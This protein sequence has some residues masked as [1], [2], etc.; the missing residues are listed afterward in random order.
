MSIN[1]DAFNRI[2]I[3]VTSANLLQFSIRE[4]STFRFFQTFAIDTTINNKLALKYKS[5]DSS[6]WINGLKLSTKSELFDFTG[7]ELVRLSFDDSVGST[8]YSKTKQIQYYD[9][10]LT[11]SE[12]ETLTSWVSFSD[13]A[14]GQLYTI[15]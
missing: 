12:L 3:E 14:N 13:M 15:Q 9:S 11:D 8:F 7:N 1:K 10:A 4:S 2:T 5:G 6:L